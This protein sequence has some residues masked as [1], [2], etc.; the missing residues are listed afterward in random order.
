MKKEETKAWFNIVVTKEL[1]SEIKELKQSGV[2]FQ[3]LIRD[4][5]RAKIVELRRDGLV[6]KQ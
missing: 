5:L 3:P 4:F 1:L 2:N 6:I